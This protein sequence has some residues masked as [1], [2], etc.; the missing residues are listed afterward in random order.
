MSMSLEL[1]LANP[2][3]LHARPATVLVRAAGRYASSVGIA[4]LDGDAGR[5]VDGKSI[6][7]VLGLG[8]SRGSRIRVSVSGPD[9][10]RCLAELAGLIRSGLGEEVAQGG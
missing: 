10:E 4:N 5:E 9:E 2:S 8:A 6:L 7:A 1:T 3:G